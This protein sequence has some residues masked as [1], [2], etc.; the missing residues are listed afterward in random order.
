[1]ILLL[2]CTSPDAPPSPPVPDEVTGDTPETF[3]GC[4]VDDAPFAGLTVETTSIPTVFRVTWTSFAT[5]EAR[6]LA[7]TDG[8]PTVTTP[9]ASTAEASEVLVR[10]LLPELAY[11][12]WVEQDGVCSSPVAAETGALHTSVPALEVA[13]FDDDAA[14]EDTW[15]P[16]VIQ[17]PERDLPAIL[18]RR[19]RVVWADPERQGMLFRAELAGDAGSVLVNGQAD[20]AEGAGKI[21]RVGWDG[22]LLE[23][24]EITGLHTD[25]VERPDGGFAGLSWDLRE[26]DG[27]KFLG[28]RLVEVDADGTEHAIWSTW[29]VF[30]LD[31][32]RTD[33]PRDF[34]SA[35]PEV[36]DWTHANGISY[37]ATLDA[38]LVT[39]N[40][41]EAVVAV[42]PGTGETLWVLA[43]TLG[44][45]THVAGG[46]LVR[47]PHSAKWLGDSVLVFNRN[48]SPECSEAVEV[49]LDFE[50]MT[51][52]RVWSYATDDCVH[53]D[54]LGEALR[55]D[56]GNTTV[57]WSAEGRMDTVS[58]DGDVVSSVQIGASETY[59]GYGERVYGLY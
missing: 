59:F 42:R 47:Q 40:Q 49:E 11:T 7:A 45:F 55:G 28:D 2:A 32:S 56:D 37:D 1:M 6:V 14:A 44:D 22:T 58:P 20:H 35:D 17:T 38:Y 15:F 16:V 46:F 51:A 30:D 34:Y 53:V 5:G 9:W 52:R 4:V 3:D 13:A 24:I 26:V 57:I 19:G 23:T 48:L 10:G 33:Y 18:D 25:F 54:F 50:E 27:R 12:V 21:Q 43:D 31:L 41:F 8:E 39:V 36:E 29:D